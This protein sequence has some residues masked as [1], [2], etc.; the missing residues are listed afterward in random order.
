MTEPFCGDQPGGRLQATQRGDVRPRESVGLHAFLLHQA[1]HRAAR[2]GTGHVGAAVG[3]GAWPGN[4]RVAGGH[5]PAIGLQRAGDARA[6]EGNG[7]LGGG[8]GLQ[9]HNGSSTA[10]ATICGLTAMSGA[11]P[12]MRSVCCTTSLNTGAATAPP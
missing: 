2:Q 11:T 9:A 4:K 8:E 7:L 1:G 6:Q 10:L 12:I 3:S 5:Q